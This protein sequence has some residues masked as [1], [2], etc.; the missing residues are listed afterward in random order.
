MLPRMREVLDEAFDLL[1]DDIISAHAKDLSRDGDAGQ[2][3]AGTGLLDYA[4][5]I[6][7]LR[8]AKYD[9]ALI[10]HG[11]REAQVDFSVGFLRDQLKKSD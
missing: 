9:G 7:L 5:Y 4:H 3:A 11:L 1:G 2:E 6:G 8:Q 10:L